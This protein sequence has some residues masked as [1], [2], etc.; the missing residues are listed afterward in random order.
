MLR[1]SDQKMIKATRKKIRLRCRY[2]KNKYLEQEAE[3]INQLAV[4][5]KL[6]KNIQVW[7]EIVKKLKIL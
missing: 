5:R 4:N 6:E 1:N 3:Q 2:L 7:I